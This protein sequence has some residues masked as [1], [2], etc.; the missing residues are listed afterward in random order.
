MLYF[1]VLPLEKA[2]K[3]WQK[4]LQFTTFIHHIYVRPSII[5]IFIKKNRSRS[6]IPLETFPY[7]AGS[8]L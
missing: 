6:L 1:S 7:V 2:E 8:G 4:N 5:K 3:K